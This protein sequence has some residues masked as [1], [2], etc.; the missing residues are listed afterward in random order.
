M[1]IKIKLIKY[2]FNLFI[3][4]KDRK[5]AKMQKEIR[6]NKSTQKRRKQNKKRS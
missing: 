5:Y 4:N 1:K 3:F 6:Y 2:N